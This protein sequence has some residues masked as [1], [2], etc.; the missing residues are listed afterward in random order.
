MWWNHLLASTRKAKEWTL[1]IWPSTIAEK[2]TIVDIRC[3][4]CSQQLHEDSFGSTTVEGTKRRFCLSL[5]PPAPSQFGLGN[6]GLPSLSSVD[7]LW[8]KYRIELS[9][10]PF[11]PCCWHLAGRSHYASSLWMSWLLSIP[12]ISPNWFYDEDLEKLLTFWWPGQALTVSIGRGHF[13]C[14]PH[15]HS[16]G[17]R[18]MKYKKKIVEGHIPIVHGFV[19][20]VDANGERF[21]HILW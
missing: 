2:I 1:E 20:L 14:L 9:P 3:N 21:Y 5:G 4:Q 11:C 12:L 8:V 19:F 13:H 17:G 6:F 10:S 18:A 15:P 16:E 7:D